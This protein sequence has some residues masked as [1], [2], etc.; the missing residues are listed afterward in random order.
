VFKSGL[1]LSRESN[2]NVQWKPKVETEVADLFVGRLICFHLDH[3]SSRIS[4]RPWLSER[5]KR[6]ERPPQVTVPNVVGQ[7]Y[8]KAEAMLKEKGLRM[9]V[10]AKRSDQNQP[11]DII[12]DQ[13]PLVGENVDLGYAVGVT[14][15]TLPPETTF[16]PR[17]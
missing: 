6:A 4:H 15:G 11:V 13:V 9:R 12:L 3:S 8:R 7:D 1:S 5:Q 10:L 17:K 16:H 14:I 2:G